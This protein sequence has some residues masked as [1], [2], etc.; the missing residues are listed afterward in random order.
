MAQIL[1]FGDSIAYGAWDKEGGWV[2]RLRKFL[3]EK[4]LLI[5]NFCN[6]DFPQVHNLS[7]SS[8][9]GENSDN[10]LERFEFETNQ[11]LEK[12][13][14]HIFIFAIGKNDS[15]FNKIK[16]NFTIPL[17]KFRENLQKLVKLAKNYSPKIVFIGIA[18]VDEL[19]INLLSWDPGISYKNENIQKYNKIIKS[20]CKENEVYFVEIFEDWMKLDYK[21]LL[22][23]GL[24]PNSEGHKKI[25]EIVKGFL[26]EN[27]IIL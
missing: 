11:R 16:N 12:S 4:T 24:H 22:E 9:K 1:V 13:K 15:A 17:E 10:L 19:K 14:K 7:V 3:D 25:F 27:K 20:V 6:I 21:K 8:E 5:P 26:I 18:T 23:D 2:Q